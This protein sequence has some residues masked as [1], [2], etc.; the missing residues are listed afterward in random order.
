MNKTLNYKI[1]S[2]VLIPLLVVN[3]TIVSSRPLIASQIAQVNKVQLQ[4]A[5]T[6]EFYDLI[7]RGKFSI[8][9]L[10]GSVKSLTYTQEF[11]ENLIRIGGRQVYD[12]ML[13]VNKKGVN[14]DIEE[15]KQ[16]Q[17]ELREF[18]NNNQEFVMSLEPE[19]RQQIVPILTIN[20]PSQMKIWQA[21]QHQQNERWKCSAVKTAPVCY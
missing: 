11:A 20:I 14:R 12:Q 15:I 16:A 4:Q 6:Q 5:L 21:E 2:T 13:D 18:I 19:V 7:I 10:Q 17:Q 9:G 8:S 3:P 1:S